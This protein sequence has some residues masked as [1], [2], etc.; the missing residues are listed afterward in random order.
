VTKVPAVQRA[1]KAQFSE[2]Y[3]CPQ[4]VGES[5]RA[6]SGQTTN[7]PSY[8]LVLYASGFFDTPASTEGVHGINCGICEREE[9]E[10]TLK[11]PSASVGRI[12]RKAMDS[13]CP[14]RSVQAENPANPRR[15]VFPPPKT[16]LKTTATKPTRPTTQLSA[17]ILPARVPSEVRL[18]GEP[19]TVP[20]SPN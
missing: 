4:A 2:S 11:S 9:G 7:T 15:I 14:K 20:H 18:F 8:I 17:S 12:P 5:R 6:A 3:G 19:C 1:E 16:Q 10:R 13:S